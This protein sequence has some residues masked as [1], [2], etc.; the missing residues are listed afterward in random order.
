MN[1]IH[2][3]Q[4]FAKLI[5]TIDFGQLAED[6]NDI[7]EANINMTEKIKT[8]ESINMK[9]EKENDTINM[10]LKT[11]TEKLQIKTDDV[12]NLTKV[13]IVQTLSKQVNEKDN[14]IRILESQLEKYKNKTV[15]TENVSEVEEKP[16]KQIKEEVVVE[17]KPKKSAK[18]EVAVPIV[19]E[20]PKK[21]I[22]EEVV[23]DFDPD[24][25]E[26]INGFELMM[27]K[28]KYYL[29]DLETNELYSILN[30]VQD[31]VVGF[32]NNSGK[33]KFNSS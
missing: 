4:A 33:P 12:T 3:L 14:M 27:Y 5:K 15:E 29:R 17:E 24:N 20:K 16:K 21:Q 32:I 18:E 25:F 7:T 26:E 22:K 30:N 8:L 13:S 19:E 10:E 2:N 6:Y 23:N 9:L 28:K 1:Q 11:L 31:K